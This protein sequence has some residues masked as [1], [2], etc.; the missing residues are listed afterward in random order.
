MGPR[1]ANG[2]L[3]LELK[4]GSL[5]VASGSPAVANALE[6]A[7]GRPRASSGSPAAA[8]ALKV[9]NGSPRVA[10]GSRPAQPS[11]WLSAARNAQKA[12]SH[13]A[14]ERRLAAWTSHASDHCC[15]KPG[16][17]FVYRIS[18]ASQSVLSAA[19]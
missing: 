15:E 4:S 3:A 12:R 2:S 16:T 8:N 9:A 10:S 19:R 7:S 14:A 6:V 11:N 17:Y 13:R 18:D 5:R 1:V